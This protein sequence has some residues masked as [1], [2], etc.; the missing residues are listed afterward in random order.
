MDYKM[1]LRMGPATDVA[2]S[3]ILNDYDSYLEDEDVEYL[4]ERL[5]D[6]QSR[7]FSDLP[8]DKNMSDKNKFIYNV[9][10]K[11][12]ELIMD[13]DTST[14]DDV[15]SLLFMLYPFLIE[16]PDRNKQQ[17]YMERLTEMV[18]DEVYGDNNIDAVEEGNCNE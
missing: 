4:M 17:L 6:L 16:N 13:L 3:S 1:L 18:Q 14:E 10:R 11:I 2:G 9:P 7:Y 8:L 12:C 15:F 5:L